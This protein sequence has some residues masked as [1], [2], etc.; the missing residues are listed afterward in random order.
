MSRSFLNSGTLIVIKK[1]II[2]N[3]VLSA[4]PHIP[5]RMSEDAGIKP[6]TVATLAVAVRRSNHSA[7]SHPQKV[8]GNQLKKY[9][10]ISQ[11]GTTN[12][13]QNFGN[14]PTSQILSH[15]PF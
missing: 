13:N 3:T 8:A 9:Y 4:A 5:L 14:K 12:K 15:Y 2:L 7:R 10:T 1:R 11:F 6:R